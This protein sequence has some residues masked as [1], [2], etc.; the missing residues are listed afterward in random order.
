MRGHW[1]HANSAAGDGGPNPSNAADG[2]GS[3]SSAAGT[4]GAQGPHLLAEVAVLCQMEELR[5]SDCTPVQ[6]KPCAELHCRTRSGIP[7][8]ASVLTTSVWEPM[9]TGARGRRAAAA[10]AGAS[11]VVLCR[12]TPA[13]RGQYGGPAEH[14]LGA[15]VPGC[16]PLSRC[17]GRSMARP[18]VRL[19]SAAA[20]RGIGT[21]EDTVTPRREPTIKEYHWSLA[22]V[23]LLQ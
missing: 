1:L 21:A 22:D 19:R 18:A 23:A 11:L 4:L 15:H 7:V 3:N 5:S 12:A 10:D 13:P 9:S 16:S 14:G 8:S 6:L 17:C 20:P 2:A